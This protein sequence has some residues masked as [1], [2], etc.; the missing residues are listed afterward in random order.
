MNFGK[1]KMVFFLL[2][3]DKE[4]RDYEKH[5]QRTPKKKDREPQM[6]Q[7]KCLEV[8][9]NESFQDKIYRE[10]S[11]IN[12]QINRMNLGELKN[13]CKSL[14]LDCYGRKDPLKR[15]LKEHYKV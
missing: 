13:Q 6:I 7:E 2:Q 5:L 11:L 8:E 10:L 3:M 1:N 9:E 15:R 14:K 12:G 4:S